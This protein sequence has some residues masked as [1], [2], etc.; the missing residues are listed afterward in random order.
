MTIPRATGYLEVFRCIIKQSPILL[1]LAILVLMIS[2]YSPQDSLELLL[3]MA[4]LTPGAPY[5][6]IT[7]IAADHEETETSHVTGSRATDESWRAIINA[8]P[9]AALTLGVDGVISHQNKLLTG[10]FPDMKVGNAMGQLLRNPD[11]Q[12]AVEMARTSSKPLVVHLN[13]RVPVARSIEATVIRLELGSDTA[14]LLVTFR[15]LTEREKLEKMRADFVA[16]AS[17]ELRTP[18][19]SLKGYIETLQGS[20]RD[21][22]TARNRFL[23]IMWTQ[24][25]RMSRLVDDLLS[26]TRVEM[27]AHLPPKG[28][29]DLNEVA[30]YV[31]QALE[32]LATSQNTQLILNELDAAAYIR[33]DREEIV[34]ALQNLVHNALKYGRENGRVDVT[35]S[36]RRS[37]DGTRETLSVAVKDDGLGISS[38]HLP[39][40][41]ERFYRVNPASSREKGGT[42]LGL[43][44]VKHIMLRHRGDLLIS[45]KVGEG[46]SFS[47]AFEELLPSPAE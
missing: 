10:L 41:V 32:P 31:V 18:L 44:I 11:L 26:L 14:R 35:V 5:P 28:K 38:H 16:N 3:A 34:Q 7:P 17:H 8:L 24:S 36:R 1:M 22:E 47:L 33:A 4:S 13:E 46:S 12:T 21:D 27:R 20:A 45:S 25:L 29:V 15:D 39:R 23:G 2:P 19:A 30:A 43:A 6:P 9:D 42:G 40:L 37:E